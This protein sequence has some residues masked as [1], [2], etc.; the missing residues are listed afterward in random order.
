[1]REMARADAKD[2]GVVVGM[3]MDVL[4]AMD[5]KFKVQ[6]RYPIDAQLVIV[7]PSARAKVNSCV[8][9]RC[10]IKS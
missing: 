8:L 5:F 2:F 7:V 6:F 10:E 3:L 1:M 4:R 9:W